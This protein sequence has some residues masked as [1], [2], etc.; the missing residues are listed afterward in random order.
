[1][2]KR[3]TSASN[4]AIN[5][6]RTMNQARTVRLNTGDSVAVGMPPL[7]IASWLSPSTPVMDT[8]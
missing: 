4:E 5:Q 6:A 1:M 8:M 7:V 3:R 2:G